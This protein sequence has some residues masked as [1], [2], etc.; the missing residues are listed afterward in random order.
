[1]VPPRRREERRALLLRAGTDLLWE[2]GLAN[3]AE[4]VTFA[5]VFA[6]LEQTRGVRVSH[7][8]V[9]GRI[10]DNQRQ[11]QRDVLARLAVADQ[12]NLEKHVEAQVRWAL[13]DR[14]RPDL[15]DPSARWRAATEL[16]RVAG[17]AALDA[18]VRSRV[19][20]R[21]TGTWALAMADVDAV[22]SKV[23]DGLRRSVHEA[24]E[25]YER[26]YDMVMQNLG[27]RMRAPFT[28][29]QLALL[30][31]AYTQGFAI[32]HGVDPTTS[33]PIDR[34]D[35]PSE[36][37]ERWT[38]YTFGLDALTSAL[39]E[40][41]PAWRPPPT[42]SAA[43]DVEPGPAATSRDPRPPDPA[44]GSPT[45]AAAGPRRREQLRELLLGAGVELLVEEGLGN[46]AAHVTFKRTIDHLEA[47]TG[48]RLTNA[49]VIGRIWQNQAQFQTEVLATVAGFGT[50]ILPPTFEA[51][52]PV[53]AT[54]GRTSPAD[55]WRTMVE[56]CR[57][58]GAVNVRSLAR[59]RRWQ[60]WLGVWALTSAR[61]QDGVEEE[62]PVADALRKGHEA[63]TA[64]YVDVLEFLF[65]QIGLRVRRGLTLRQL[66]VAATALVEGSALRLQGI[67]RETGV[68]HRPT[69][70]GGQDREW[71][72]FAV[73]LEALVTAFVEPDPGWPREA[74][75]C[76]MRPAP[77][78]G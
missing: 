8:S 11:Y 9:I 65:D 70:P 57:V 58:G 72:L 19:W 21:W 30:V 71:T 17:Q 49:A 29:R 77:G 66:T 42:P 54:G 61:L 13:S 18:V 39:V 43:P 67:G 27:L 7:A 31:G 44:A 3:G 14:R 26:A 50:E 32:R 25:R 33:A 41:D 46:A 40:L 73:G 55:R 15:A 38:L 28:V 24:T 47:T 64:R 16:V 51:L 63:T 48:I 6:R 2:E 12:W 78:Q 74:E 23:F 75:S 1:M 10:W 76:P 45:T 34:P 52:V 53:L 22:D 68:V 37:G 56:L 59:S 60:R 5:R 62:R 36:R 69:G 4:H 35:G 20:P